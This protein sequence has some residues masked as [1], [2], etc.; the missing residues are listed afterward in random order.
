MF[1]RWATGD[2]RCRI[3]VAVRDI[4]PPAGIYARS[5]GAARHEQA[6]GVH[7]PLT[8]SALVLLPL[9]PGDG[10]GLVLV[11]ADLGWFPLADDECALRA[12]LCAAAG[13]GAAQL[14]L[15]L[16]HTHSGPSLNTRCAE[17]PGGA[18][19]APYLAQL[20]DIGA[21]AIA[22]AHAAAR[23]G[24]VRAGYGSCTLATRRDLWL[25]ATQG[26]VTGSDLAEPA[27]D[28]VLV[29]R[30]S[31]DAGAPLATLVNYACHPTTL[32]WQNPLI[33]PDYVGAMREVVEQATGAPCIFLYGAGGDLGPRDGF[34]GDTAVADRN[35]RQLGYA[36]LAALAGLPPAG[37]QRAFAGVVASGANL[38]T[39]H[40]V[41]HDAARLA[42]C[43][44]LQAHQHLVPLARKPRPDAVRA[45]ASGADPRAEAEKALRR[46]LVQLALGDADPV[47]RPLWAWRIGD[48]LLLA[49]PDE[50]YSA[51]Q[52]TLRARFADRPVI[53]LG[54]TNGAIGYLVPRASYDLGLYQEQQSP[55]AAG[56]F[57]QVLAAALAAL[58]AL[59]DAP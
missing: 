35:G 15:N 2:A 40:D 19:I 27:D 37:T 54:V 46:E 52:A 4:T 47:P 45:P 57:E 18:L 3:G 42:A 25:D 31:D 17:R 5:W 58:A 56:C 23:P 53:V 51:L 36:A 8:L 33:S 38:G 29:A 21:D 28:T 22:A 7:R 48:L 26:Y 14:L 34:V 30:I 13:V 24:W 6:S 39:W 20:A 55:F 32:A 50:A 9:E 12:Q 59:A 1:W 43:R 16:S 11:A 44:R 49:C 41:P 10:A